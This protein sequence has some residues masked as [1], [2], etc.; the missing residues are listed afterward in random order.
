MSVLVAAI[1]GRPKDG[2]LCLSSVGDRRAELED[3][4]V[5]A[6]VAVSVLHFVF[7]PGRSLSIVS[8]VC[9]EGM[10]GESCIVLV[11]QYT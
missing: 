5:A 2:N 6:G 8:D 1:C 11:G 7:V 10:L 3:S 9:A 4:L